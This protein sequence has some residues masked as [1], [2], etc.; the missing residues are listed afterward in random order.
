MLL[1]ARFLMIMYLN[2][3]EVI[4]CPRFLKEEQSKLS[5]LMQPHV[6]YIVTVIFYGHNDKL[7]FLRLIVA[8]RV[9]PWRYLS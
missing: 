3:T 9:F 7:D 1:E 8:C 4:L 5:V 2:Y 6:S